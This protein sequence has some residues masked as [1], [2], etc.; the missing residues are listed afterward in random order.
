MAVEGPDTGIVGLD[1]DHVRRVFFDHEGVASRRVGAGL[2]GRVRTA[3]DE[4]DQALGVLV[5]PCGRELGEDLEVVA[6]EM[7]F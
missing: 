4:V 7:P 5:E 1:G 3:R 2:A 6:V